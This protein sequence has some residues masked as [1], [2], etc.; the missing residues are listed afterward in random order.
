MRERV[1]I[2]DNQAGY[3]VAVTAEVF[4]GAVN[5]DISA[6]LDRSLE[7]RRH[8]GII[9]NGENTVLFRQSRDRREVCDRQQRICRAFDEDRLDLGGDFALQR[10]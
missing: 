6:Q 7:V 2:D 4:C 1:I 8:K 9:D 5:N 3:N 10:G